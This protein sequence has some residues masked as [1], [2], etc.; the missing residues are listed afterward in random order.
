[1]TLITTDEARVLQFLSEDGGFT[2][3]RIAV[4]LYGNA[5]LRRDSQN[6]ARMCRSL[7]LRHLVRTLDEQ[8]PVVWC[9]TPNGT[10]ALER[11]S[12]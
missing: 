9:R 2:T 1:M 4:E 7:N 5:N 11:H 6:V 3:H 8:K 12:K 10:V